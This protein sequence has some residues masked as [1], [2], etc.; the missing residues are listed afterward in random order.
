[1]NKMNL[2]LAAIAALSGFSA[3]SSASAQAPAQ[4]VIDIFDWQ[5]EGPGCPSKDKVQI[6]ATRTGERSTIVLSFDN[7]RASVTD[8]DT[9][10]SSNCQITLYLRAPKGLRTALNTITY[11]G[12][13]FLAPGQSGQLSATYSWANRPVVARTASPKVLRPADNGPFKFVDQV[14]VEQ[15]SRCESVETFVIKSG[16]QLRNSDSAPAAGYVKVTNTEV[17]Q[18]PTVQNTLLPPLRSGVII[19]FRLGG[20]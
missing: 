7:Y 6:K 4:P 8:E 18:R 11:Y 14:D 10:G 9:D 20:C 12:T 3:A 19:D 1:M 17:E 15:W 13:A 16:I 2:L 5:P